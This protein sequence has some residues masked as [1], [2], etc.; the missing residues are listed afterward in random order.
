MNTN[1]PQKYSNNFFHNIITKIKLWFFNRKKTTDSLPTPIPD[2]VEKTREDNKS[3]FIE[4]IK[5]DTVDKN[6]DYEKRK[7]KNMIKWCT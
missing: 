5:V 7:F 3:S 4:S 1:L 6:K 2:V